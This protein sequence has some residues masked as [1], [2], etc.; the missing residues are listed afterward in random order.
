MTGSGSLAS[1]VERLGSNVDRF[2]ETFARDLARELHAHAERLELPLV[3]RLGLVDVVVSFRMDRRMRLV[4]TGGFADAPGEVTVSW[5]ERD[6]PQVPVVLLSTPRAEP[7]TFAT[8][9]FSVRGRRAELLVP[10]PPLPAGL[11]V[12]VRVLATIG[13]EVE[14]RVRAH[15]LEASVGPE[16]LRLLEE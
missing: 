14:Y 4:I 16:S 5:D 9:D 8:L 10:A 11:E 3:E 7:Y 6:F 12:R 15:G 1:L 13:D 2:D